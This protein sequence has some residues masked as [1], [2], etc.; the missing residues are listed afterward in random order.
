MILDSMSKYEVMSILRKEFDEE[1][2]CHYSKVIL[3]RIKPLLY[4]RCK[5]EKKTISLGWDSFVTSNNNLFK[6][7][8]RGGIASDMPLFVCEF[9][10]RGK[11]CYANFF[12]EEKVVV[13]QSHCLQRYAER[14]LDKSINSREVF[15]DYLVKKQRSAYNIVLPTPTHEYSYYFGL[16][17]ALF[18]GDFDISHPKSPFLWCNTCLSFNETRYSQ[19][20]ITKSLHEMQLFVE[21]AKCDLSDI[22]NEPI[23]KHYLLKCKNDKNDKNLLRL[24]NFLTQKYLLLQLHLSF[25]FDF[26]KLFINEIKVS[27]EYIERHLINNGIN[28]KSLSPFSVNHGIAWK[29]EIDYVKKN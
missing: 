1:V 24:I 22:Q 13:Y 16:A 2:L 26:T 19:S 23:L 25:N 8:K 9:R 20:R 11:V 6:I 18:F 4:Q 3:P 28:P 10:W 29:G 27:I 17:G 12:P 5:R 7:L 21:E 14:I 15:Y